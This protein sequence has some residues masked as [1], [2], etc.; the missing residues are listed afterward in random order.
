MDVQDWER[1]K[2]IFEEALSVEPAERAAYV[3]AA[4][5]DETVL[6][7]TVEELLKNHSSDPR[8]PRETSLG[9][10][11]E[12]GQLIANRFRII[13]FIDSG[14]MGEVY[15]VDDHRLHRRLALKTLRPSE[16]ITEEAIQRFQR[17][18][19]VAQ[20][21]THENLCRVF[22]YVEHWSSGNTGEPRLIPCLTMELVRGE[23]L[24]QHLS[25]GP[26]ELND[27]LMLI[28]Q[29]AAGLDYLH[30]HDIIHRDLKPSNIMLTHTRDGQRRAVVMDFGLAKISGPDSDLFA[31]RTDML[32]GAPYFMAPEIFRGEAHSAASDI[33][34]FGLIVDEMV[35]RSRAFSVSSLH[36]LYF[37]KLWETPIPPS[38]RGDLPALWEQVILQCLDVQPKNRFSRAGDAVSVLE[39]I[40][41]PRVHT[42][43]AS[44]AR[45]APRKRLAVWAAAIIILVLLI[46]AMIIARMALTPA[47][48]SIDVFDIENRTGDSSYDYL[49]KGT[50]DE[51]VRR[52][53]EIVDAHVIT[54][55]STRSKAP[56]RTPSLFSFDGELQQLEGQVR[57]SVRLTDDQNN[58]TWSQDF[59]K[60]QM[61]D[62]LALQS[63]ITNETMLAIQRHLALGGLG[64]T[65]ER[66]P[67]S[68]VL[69]N[70]GNWIG[71]TARSDSPRPPT[72]SNAAL[73]DFMHAHHRMANASPNDLTYAIV[74]LKNATAK[75]PE[76]ALA[77]ASLAEAHIL[78][79][80]YSYFPFSEMLDAARQHANK[81]VSIAPDLPEAYE[82]L[83]VV[84]RMEW[85]LKDSREN[86]KK[87][88][89][90]KPTL[91]TARLRYAG[92]LLQFGHS[93]EG[94]VEARRAVDADPYNPIQTAAYGLYLFLAGEYQECLTVLEPAA[95][96]KD[97]LGPAHNLGDLYA[98]LAEVSSGAQREQ[99]FQKAFEQAD[100]VAQIEQRVR[101]GENVSTPR[102]DEMYAHFHSMRG[103]SRA[104]KPYLDRMLKGMRAGSVSPAHVAWIYA[105]QGRED[106]ALDLIERAAAARDQ[107]LM[108]MQLMPV[109]EKL[110]KHPRFEKVLDELGLRDS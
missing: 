26:I 21:V 15:E 18:I 84:Q 7:E 101:L 96:G 88:L 66:G 81:A 86:F 47:A 105:A 27:A 42:E 43:P 34:A 87:A 17:E 63:Q 5:G 65:I 38:K 52:L 97:A 69:L 100:R 102:A 62:A 70:I 91:S 33:Y 83:A 55:H 109:F 11:F 103:D 104:A 39:G 60:D 46:P 93:Q 36:A 107:H 8:P 85:E 41:A 71:R 106:E 50:T 44:A 28:R 51:L 32:A 73:D 25:S 2:V 78:M 80:N 6:R 54:L 35:T 79:T 12:V 19:R 45:I 40:S 10:V 74:K 90:L 61:S 3:E 37:A 13:R 72:T 99:Y 75:D 92:L 31:S 95:L 108:F 57:L 16:G 20:G 67:M 59:G 23:S 68:T 76:F 94:I 98:R 48:A 82:A 53:P 49:V 4:C 77:Y 22:D 29:I 58:V 9:P 110:R 56:A 30:D 24:A 89:A 14:A 64:K 1:V